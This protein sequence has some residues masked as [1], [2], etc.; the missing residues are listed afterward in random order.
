M[1][2]IL[3]PIALYYTNIELDLFQPSE[4]IWLEIIVEIE[5]INGNSKTSRMHFHSKFHDGKITTELYGR[6]GNAISVD[7]VLPLK[8]HVQVR[9]FKNGEKET[10]K[11]GNRGELIEETWLNT[12]QTIDTKTLE[13]E[14]NKLISIKEKD[15]IDNPSKKLFY[16]Q[17]RLIRVKSYQDRKLILTQELKYNHENLVV[18][19]VNTDNKKTIKRIDLIYNDANKL[20]QSIE[21][22]VNFSKSN[23]I[24]IELI[25]YSYH[26]NGK[27]KRRLLSIFDDESLSN[28][29]Y[30]YQ[31]DFNESGLVIDEIES[32]LLHDLKI[33]RKYRYILK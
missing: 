23:N 9:I 4:P 5:T 12:D 10:K 14:D 3:D 31:E 2:I 19:I 8:D 22:P 16:N 29:N 13:Y 21:K 15:G 20:I 32:K 24:Q 33:H 27:L 30:R 18:E 1:T 6:K 11:F 26:N 25:E 7:E 17:Q 28:L